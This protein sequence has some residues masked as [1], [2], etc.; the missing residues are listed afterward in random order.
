[1]P[2]AK[3]EFSIYVFLLDGESLHIF[4]RWL[5]RDAFAAASPIY[6]PGFLEVEHTWEGGAA[7]TSPAVA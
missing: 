5:I 6:S 4:D 1:L 7:E 2:L 3:G